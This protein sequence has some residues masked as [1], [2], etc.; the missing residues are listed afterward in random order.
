MGRQKNRALTLSE[1]EGFA[2]GKKRGWDWMELNHREAFRMALQKGLILRGEGGQISLPD[3]TIKNP[4]KR[5][6]MA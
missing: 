4:T 5:M 1:S 3:Y 6:I 2:L